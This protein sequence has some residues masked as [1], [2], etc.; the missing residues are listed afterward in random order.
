MLGL[1]FY[2]CAPTPVGP[3]FNDQRH[4]RFGVDPNREAE[5][6]IASQRERGYP[7]AVRVLGQH[8]TALG[9][10]DKG[11]RSNT[12][13]VL[14]QRGIAVALDSRP[15]TLLQSAVTY[16][17]IQPE[18]VGSHDVD[19]DGFEEIVIE[20]RSG[21]KSCLR[22]YRV[23]DVG[24]VDPVGMDT[25]LLG[26]EFCAD[27][28]I[29]LDRDGVIELV[30]E[31][32]LTG[33][34]R[35]G[36][37]AAGPHLQLPLWAAQHRFVARAGSAAQKAWL[38]QERARR[39]A[40]LQRARGR[41]DSANSYALAIELAALAHLEG[42]DP[43][44]QLGAF[45]RALSGLMLTAE[46]S[47][48]TVGA[49]A[50]IYNE[51]NAP[52]RGQA[53]ALSGPVKAV[54]TTEKPAPGEQRT[55][56]RAG[57]TPAAS[58]SASPPRVATR[59]QED[60]PL[61]RSLLEQR[62]AA[63]TA[64]EDEPPSTQHGWNLR[65]SPGAARTASVD[66]TAA[67]EPTSEAHQSRPSAATR[68][69]PETRLAATRTGEFADARQS[70]PHS[71]PLAAPAPRGDEPVLEEGDIVITPESAAAEEARRR[72]SRAGARMRT[73]LLSSAA[74]A[75]DHAP[76]PAQP[77]RE[78][79]TAPTLP[80]SG[81][82]TVP[83]PLPAP[84]ASGRATASASLPAPP[85]RDDAQR[86]VVSPGTLPL[87]TAD[88]VTAHRAAARERANAAVAARIRAATARRAAAAERREAQIVRMGIQPTDAASA[89]AL[90]ETVAAHVAAAQ[91][92]AA[93]AAG[94]A[95]E[96]EQ[97]RAALVEH[98]A[99]AYPV[100]AERPPH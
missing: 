47:V 48:A 63:R 75:P 21:A 56:E 15:Q 34:V 89:A 90:R 29:D 92:Y 27:S 17:L 66:R 52:E 5:S 14:T 23:R 62:Q 70:R 97:H 85:A 10:M 24:F 53:A 32:D 1:G 50:R 69:E 100:R 88:D 46:Q 31:L 8:F 40:E 7:L 22:L 11:G 76:A 43:A 42:S 16:A 13:R 57:P 82:A 18:V 4:L 25:R 45:D 37:N 83:A 81:R 26:Q 77:A 36:A 39:E 96:A 58:S 68:V 78:G 28:V 94:A 6:V 3:F 91:R 64:S 30:A 55:P 60:D 84:P 74:K 44:T 33:F 54:N 2:G 9:F 59:A 20:E 99:A 79:A 73:P 80:T 41:L 67:A 35:F 61:V 71:G 72:A 95:S 93:E 86:A 12:V 65:A 19:G 87:Q 38:A 98:K 49:R 51:W